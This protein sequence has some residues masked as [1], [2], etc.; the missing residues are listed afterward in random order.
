MK[1][2]ERL[3]ALDWRAIEAKRDRGSN[4][5]EEGLP[6]LRLGYDA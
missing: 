3:D 1:L 6:Y 2:F 5:D 4:G